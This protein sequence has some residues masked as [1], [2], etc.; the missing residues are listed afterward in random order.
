MSTVLSIGRSIYQ[1]AFEDTLWKSF[2]SELKIS[3]QIHIKMT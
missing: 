3:I 2:L 1:F